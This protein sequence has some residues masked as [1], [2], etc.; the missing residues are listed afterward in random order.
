LLR[1][2][3]FDAFKESQYGDMM[4]MLF[5]KTDQCDLEFIEEIAKAARR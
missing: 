5:C 3:D 2:K 4:A 1:R